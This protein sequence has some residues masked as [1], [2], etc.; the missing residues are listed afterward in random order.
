MKRSHCSPR[1]VTPC[2]FV[3]ELSP[4]GNATSSPS[5]KSLTKAG[6]KQRPPTLS[7][8]ALLCSLLDGPCEDL[9]HRRCQCL[10]IENDQPGVALNRYLTPWDRSLPDSTSS[11]C[12]RTRPCRA[13]TR[14]SL[15]TRSQHSRLPC[16]RRN[17]PV[18]EM[19]ATAPSAV[20]ELFTLYPWWVE[21]PSLTAGFAPCESLRGDVQKQYSRWCCRAVS[22]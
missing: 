2:G 6:T 20:P 3:A 9:L 16:R 7:Q 5:A 19:V 11:W 17:R 14:S 13:L 18:R 4:G 8:G 10:V 1:Y 12:R 21:Q 15:Q 22:W